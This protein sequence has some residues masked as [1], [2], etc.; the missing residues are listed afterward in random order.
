MKKILIIVLVVS[1]IAGYLYYRKEKSKII[2]FVSKSGDTMVLSLGGKNVNIDLKSGVAIKDGDFIIL[3]NIK[4]KVISAFRQ[5]AG[6][7]RDNYK[8]FKY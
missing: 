6:G 7:V 1:V 5:L 3:N 4:D 8:E 2:T